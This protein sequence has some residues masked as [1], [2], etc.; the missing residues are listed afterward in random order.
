MHLFMNKICMSPDEV[1]HTF[2][3]GDLYELETT[4]VYT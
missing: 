4:L 3:A 1:A 2:M